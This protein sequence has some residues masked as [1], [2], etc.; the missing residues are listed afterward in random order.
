M[1]WPL[2]RAGAAGRAVC[3]LAAM[4]AA[5]GVAG[6][7]LPSLAPA[8]FTHAQLLS[9]TSEL[10]FEEAQ[11]PVLARDGEYVAFQGT[12]ATE[13]GVWRRDLQT[14]AVEPVAVGGEGSESAPSAP[15]ASAPS[16]SA[17]GRYV[18]FTT[19]ADLEPERIGK[20]GPEGEPAVDIG[21]PEV[22][23]RDMD[24]QPGEEGAYTLASALNG[25]G[26]G[27]TFADCP[28]EAKGVAG[29]QTAP[30][31]ALGESER[32]EMSVA[33]TVLSQSNLYP[34]PGEPARLT[35][36]S[37]VAVRNL[38]TDATTLVSVT[39]EGL[40]TPGGGAFPSQAS[41]SIPGLSIGN[42]RLFGVQIS[43]SSAAISGDGGT[44]A[45][46]GT[47]V[48]AQTSDGGEPAPKEV[49]PLWRRI[50]AGP[51]AVTKRL[52]AGAGLDFDY[53]K[54]A[55]ADESIVE[56]GSFVDTVSQSMF[57]AP[58]LDQNGQEVALIA[59]APPESALGSLGLGNEPQSDAYLVRVG[60]EA[61]AQPQVSALTETPDYGVP[62]TNG[63][64]GDITNVAISP[65]GSR[66]AF[67]AGRSQLTLPTLAAV[68][69][70][71][72]G[73]ASY[74]A[75]LPLGTIQ[76]ATVDYE[77]D[78]SAGPATLLSVSNDGTLA[79]ASNATNLFY[80][81]ALQTS[82]VYLDQEVPD[83][84]AP[85]SELI[86][87]APNEA[88]PQQE[89]RLSATADAEPDGAVL[90][91]VQAP[92]GGRIAA[93]ARAQL[94]LGGGSRARASR[95]TSKKAGHVDRGA[96]SA[97]RVKLATRTVARAAARTGAPATVHLL[98]RPDAHYHSKVAA[99]HGL[100][101]LLSV[102]FAAAGHP[103][104]TTQIPVTFHARSDG[105]R[106]SKG[107]S[108]RVSRAGRHVRRR[109]SEAAR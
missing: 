83:R 34:Y 33:F 74:V 8:T 53:T 24:K 98:L 62:S 72:D 2:R 80:G 13:S 7:A 3:V 76:S 50:A 36:A 41:E 105:K 47:D 68:G 23:V 30:A 26:E 32:G 96:G 45:W 94:A 44:V 42:N 97:T 102:S 18:A 100:Y 4:L 85:G 16:I 65:D 20:D 99:A 101:A 37:Q 57:I 66:V 25:G 1:I 79:F 75:N 73:S 21:C 88:P 35:P 82:E 78:E 51:A 63:A 61:G 19:T 14:G 39:P 71:A 108:K 59:N 86:G 109:A 77:G 95:H 55:G 12:L 89:W 56:E 91:T 70:P 67:D 40:P 92:G 54:D 104:L 43:G 52:L 58:A 81:D 60:P 27:I 87:S 107:P 22:Y 49:E 106:K 103:A 5:V 15:D 38:A 11:A 6:L 10:Q 9:G 17:D 84:E 64:Y 90:V 31:V 48:P 29:A 93:A 28:A 69:L 46:L